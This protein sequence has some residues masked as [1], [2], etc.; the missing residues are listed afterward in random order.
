VTRSNGLRILIIAVACSLTGCNPLVS[1]P[2]SQAG[3][4]PGI[5]Q[6]PSTQS[7][8]QTFNLNSTTQ[9]NYSIGSSTIDFTVN[10]CELTSA[11]QT[12]NATNAFAG[13]S[14]VGAAFWDGN[15]LRLNSAASNLELDSSWTPAWSNLIAYFKLNETSGTSLPGSVFDS[16]P[17]GLNVGTPTNITFG[18]PGA[19]LGLNTSASFLG[20]PSSITIPVSTSFQPTRITV[21]MWVQFNSDSDTYQYLMDNTWG[22]SGILIQI[23]PGLTA[24]DFDISNVGDFSLTYPFQTGTWYYFAF[25]YNGTAMDIYLNGVK[26]IELPVAGTPDIQWASNSHLFIGRGS[27]P[28]CAGDA[29][30]LNAEMDD[31][32]IWDTGLTAEAIASIYQHQSAAHAGT[33]NS[34]IM[35]S[36]SSDAS[37]TNLSWV[38]TLPFFKELPDSFT[39]TPISEIASDYSSQTSNLMNGI[40]GL[41]H[42][43]E[44]TGASAMVDSSG[45]GNN[46]D[47]TSATFGSPGKFGASA[48]F[49]TG[50]NIISAV[51]NLPVAATP[52]T[53]SFWMNTGSTGSASLFSYG[54]GAPGQLFEVDLFNSN[55]LIIHWWGGYAQGIIYSINTWSHIVAVYDGVNA[56]LYQDG[57]LTSTQAVSLNTGASSVTFG[58]GTLG[59]YAGNLDEV[60]LWSRALSANEVTELYRRGANRIKYQV[61]TCQHAADCTN[62]PN[63][64]GPDGTN[65]T[66]FSEL[67][68]TTAYDKVNNVPSGSVNAGLPNM[69]FSNF[70][71]TQPAANRYF[72]YRTILESDDTS[73][74]CNYDGTGVPNTWCSPE[75]KSTSVGP[76][77]YG[78]SV[79]TVSNSTGQGYVTLSSFAETLGTGGCTTGVVYNL[80]KDNST[81]YYWNG[82]AW[83]LANGSVVQANAATSINSNIATFPVQ[84]G[85]GTLYFKAFLQSSGTSTCSLS[86]VSVGG[87]K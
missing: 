45:N 59:S 10:S 42:L 69:I 14:L 39:T 43:D 16:S 61:Q 35:D 37:W 63:W 73:T 6:T 31:I 52:R 64:Q 23:F 62:S 74:N 9:A 11:S 26:Q 56:N 53:V 44:V 84:V 40:L 54:T 1:T 77:H 86:G 82:S 33:I 22:A 36:L 24:L 41:W 60:S 57:I 15:Y 27:D 58:S 55:H 30:A 21:G 2:T 79:N 75:L 25:S 46:S 19:H 83:T 71:G 17:L 48:N 76:G 5:D 87:T 20:S 51:S 68:N 38:P 80:S 34:R 13:G 47:S 7:F 65:Q 12:D 66:Y 70:A 85:T 18:E 50:T 78:N 72:Q 4:N 29:C 3:F 49:S 8:S 67:D 32:A 28:S 81:W